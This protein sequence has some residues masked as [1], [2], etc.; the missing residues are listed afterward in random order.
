M[1]HIMQLL[2]PQR[3]C[4]VAIAWDDAKTMEGLACLELQIAADAISKTPQCAICGSTTFH[5]EDGIT[6]FKTMAEARP[7]IEACAV[8]QQVSRELL[9]RSADRN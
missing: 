9:T 6:R 7:H 1:I 2:C 5:R 8:A 4:F 3:H